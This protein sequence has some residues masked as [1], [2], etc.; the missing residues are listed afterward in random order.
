VDAPGARDEP[1]ARLGEAEARAVGGDD[2]VA[3]ERDL[4]PAAGR[5]PV[6]GRDQRLRAAVAARDRAEARARIDP[7]R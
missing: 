5:D 2:D 6:D 3:R 7:P 4:E 1:D